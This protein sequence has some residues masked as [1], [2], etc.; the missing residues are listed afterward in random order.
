MQKTYNSVT[1]AFGLD[2]IDQNKE[3]KG[4]IKK[5]PEVVQEPVLY[6]D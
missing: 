4:S 3:Q 5:V 6:K 2:E 1:K